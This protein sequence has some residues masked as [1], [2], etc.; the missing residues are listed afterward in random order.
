M[1]DVTGNFKYGVYHPECYNKINGF[2]TM[3]T[4]ADLDADRL[5]AC[6]DTAIAAGLNPTLES[7]QLQIFNETS[8]DPADLDDFNRRRVEKRVQE[9][10]ESRQNGF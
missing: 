10:W 8:V 7:V 2:Q 6:F 9:I 4:Q 1:F 5:I 3:V